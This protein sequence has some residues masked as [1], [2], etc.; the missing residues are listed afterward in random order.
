MS[1]PHAAVDLNQF[2]NT[3]VG[4]GYQA[5]HV[6]RQKH[7]ASTVTIIDQT[8]PSASN[9]KKPPTKKSK[10][11]KKKKQK[12]DPRV[13]RYLQVAGLR[14]FRKELESIVQSS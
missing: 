11:T 10:K 7:G 9:S 8:Q 13:A 6:V 1:N 14:Q 3:V 12:L 2:R 5:Q 4:Q